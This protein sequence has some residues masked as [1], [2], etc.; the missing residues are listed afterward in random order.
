MPT[1]FT[2]AGHSYSLFTGEDSEGVQTIA[3][4]ALPAAARAQAVIRAHSAIPGHKGASFGA[5]GD[6]ST[7]QTGRL[8][9]I[10]VGNLSVPLRERFFGIYVTSVQ[11]GK[12]GAIQ[13]IVDTTDV[14]PGSSTRRWR[15]LST[16]VTYM[17]SVVFLGTDAEP[18]SDGRELIV[19]WSAS[20]KSSQILLDGAKCN[21]SMV[22]APQISSAPRPPAS[23]GW[24]SSSRFLASGTASGQLPSVRRWLVF[25]AHHGTNGAGIFSLD[26]DETSASPPSQC[27]RL[28]AG[29]STVM[30]HTRPAQRFARFG[31]PVGTPDDGQVVF[32]GEGGQGLMGIYAADLS[33]GSLRRLVDT[34]AATGDRD[35]SRFASFPHAP[36][37]AAGLL[38]FYGDT[39]PDASQSG[40]YALPL[41]GPATAPWPVAT[42]RGSNLTYMIASYNSFDGRCLSFYG[43]GESEDG[44][45]VIDPARKPKS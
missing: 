30:P 2:A 27:P 44:L 29:I 13:K 32:V 40:M 20:S 25:F 18:S 33:G 10:G 38:T 22:S 36:S 14:A 37:A 28:V 16:P 39:A 42:L 43:S 12:V 31:G 45:Y 6:L 23:V 4:Q 41:T 17:D 19:R 11:S 34:S 1:A 24:R 35:G 9:F 3:L 21:L 7:T 8:G 5:F 26:I 15:S